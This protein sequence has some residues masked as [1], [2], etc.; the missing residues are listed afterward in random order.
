[1]SRGRFKPC[2]TV[3]HGVPLPCR[4]LHSDQLQVLDFLNRD[5]SDFRA[6]W[7]PASH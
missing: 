5:M 6:G 4:A 2:V 1:M 7:L 3:R